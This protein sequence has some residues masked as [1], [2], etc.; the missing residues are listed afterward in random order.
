MTKVFLEFVEDSEGEYTEW[1][2]AGVFASHPHSEETELELL[3]RGISV[4][5]RDLQP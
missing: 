5:E 3:S 4:E 1:R 2:L